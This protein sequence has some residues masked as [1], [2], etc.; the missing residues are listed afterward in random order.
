MKNKDYVLVIWQ[1]GMDGGVSDAKTIYKRVKNDL[2]TPLFY[3]AGKRKWD[4]YESV[5]PKCREVQI[6]LV[7][8]ASEYP[9]NSTK[10]LTHEEVFLIGL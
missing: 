2:Y 9:I 5:Y 10:W 6:S 4:N 1:D 7:D 3:C 8:L